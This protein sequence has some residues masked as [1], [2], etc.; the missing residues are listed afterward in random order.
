MK[1][2]H[3]WIVL[4]CAALAGLA[5]CGGPAP[6]VA[7]VAP[8]TGEVQGTVPPSTPF[9][10]DIHEDSRARLPQINP[11]DLDA[12]GQRVYDIMVNPDSRYAEGLSG[13][14]G[15]W[16]YSPQ[17]AEHVFPASSYLRFETQFDQRLTELAILT[18]AR[19][20][21][22]QYEWTQHE[23]RAIDAGLEDEIIDI[24]KHRRDTAG[25]GD[26][27]ATIIAFGREVVSGEK[28]SSETFAHALELFGEKGVMNLAGL[29]G[30]Y[31][32]VNISIKTF[33]VQLA[34]DRAPTLPM[35]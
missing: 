29:I 35:P 16:M 5:A 17:M 15:M 21:N 24:V 32:F 31:N 23:V 9:P 34:P 10:P 7:D 4:A 25:L 19:E 13:P 12:Y 20:V 8:A 33:D 18:T 1:P 26:V 28:L 3:L 14:L 6:G 2:F 22:S 27:E 30:Y 11:A